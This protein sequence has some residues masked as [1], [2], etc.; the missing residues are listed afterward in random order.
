MRRLPVTFRPNAIADIDAIFLYVLG[1]SRDLAIS[2]GFVDRI[3]TR[4]E[5]IG[6][7]PL[8]GVAR[9]DLGDGIRLVPFEKSAVIRYRIVLYRIVDATVE[10][11]NAFYRGRD[12]DALLR[13]KS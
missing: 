5:A 4:R 12:Y 1:V 10:I 7:I 2:A 6:A 13:N 8:G 11:T 3:D 9:S